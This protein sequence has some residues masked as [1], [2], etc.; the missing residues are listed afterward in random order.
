MIITID[1]KLFRESAR[2]SNQPT[3]KFVVVFCPRLHPVTYEDNLILRPNLLVP[4]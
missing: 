4:L 1:N 2:Y 3:A